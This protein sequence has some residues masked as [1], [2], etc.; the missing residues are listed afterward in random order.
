M[1]RLLLPIG[2]LVL[3][4]CASASIVASETA[5]STTTTTTIATD[6]FSTSDGLEC[7]ID[8]MEDQD[9]GLFAEGE[10]IAPLTEENTPEG[11]AEWFLSPAN[12]DWQLRLDWQEL[13]LDPK[14]SSGNTFFFID[15][16]GYPYARIEAK[17]REGVW[18]VGRMSSC[19]PEGDVYAPGR[20]DFLPIPTSDGWLPGNPELECNG[21]RVSL[22]FLLPGESI[23]LE[24]AIPE[25]VPA[26]AE[27]LAN[28]EGQFWPQDGWVV[29]DFQE[30]SVTIASPADD[31]IALM[32]LR[33]DGNGWAWDSSSVGED[34][35][36]AI[37][38]D[39]ANA[40][41]WTVT[42]S[43]PE[44]S[45]VTVS[46]TEIECVGGEPMSDR[47]RDPLVALTPDIAYILL[48]ADRPD[49]ERNAC[50]GNPSTEV[51]IE[52]DEPLG[53]RTIQDARTPLGKISQY[54]NN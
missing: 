33:N 10:A 41:A 14:R 38:L 2:L 20:D 22:E 21:A 11:V 23:T 24:E 17:Q 19:A 48:S 28:E 46:A 13:T 44:S 45:S 9:E 12:A 47:L 5:D 36:I 6:R 31:G 53:S 54:L 1:R 43:T 30:R 40:V 8:L 15:P 26:L 50:P 4:S 7:P 25:A 16:D 39:D 49:S 29:V 27:F 3:T 42:D 18:L 51:V 34:C 37:V 32:A 35:D 52:L